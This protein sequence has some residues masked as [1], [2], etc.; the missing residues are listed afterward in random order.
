MKRIPRP[1]NSEA[2]L[3]LDRSQDWT[4]SPQ[5]SQAQSP[6]SI[7]TATPSQPLRD[8]H[9]NMEEPQNASSPVILISSGS[10]K[11][12]YATSLQTVDLLS[13]SESQLFERTSHTSS[14]QEDSQITDSRPSVF[15]VLGL[16]QIISAPQPG[17]GEER[18]VTHISCPLQDFAKQLPFARFF[19]P[20]EVTRDIRVLERGYWLLEIRIVAEEVAEAAR[21]AEKDK[22]QG[23]SMQE[24]FQGATTAERLLKYDEAK[25]DGSLYQSGQSAEL[26]AQGLWTENEL[27]QFWKSFSSFIENSKAGWGTRLVGEDVSDE[28]GEVVMVRIRIF[29]WGEVLGHIYLAL[30][31]LSDKLAARIPMH[32]IASD[33]THVVRMAGTRSGRGSLLPWMRKGPEGEKGCWGIA[34]AGLD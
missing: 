10:S 25:R 23:H 8:Q 20:I 32:W 13:S 19:R 33:G 1:A 17:V 30:W 16:Q 14:V 28:S 29:T 15:E 26:R 11:Q 5:T 9:T 7:S 4:S 22:I 18:F 31:V 2:F 12:A 24:R 21:S 6:S 3:L 34:F 27:V